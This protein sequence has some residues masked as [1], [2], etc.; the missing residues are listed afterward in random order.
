MLFQFLSIDFSK[1]GLQR[2]RKGKSIVFMMTFYHMI[3][4]Y[5]MIFNHM[6]W[7]QPAPS[8]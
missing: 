3:L 7:V 4:G 5:H 6:I 1:I 2:G 8:L